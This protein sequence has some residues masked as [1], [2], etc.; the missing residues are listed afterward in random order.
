VPRVYIFDDLNNVT[1]DPHVV[2]RTEELVVVYHVEGRAEVEVANIEI[3]IEVARVVESI[4]QVLELALGVT[5]EYAPLLAYME[6][7]VPKA[8][9]QCHIGDSASPK[10]IK[11]TS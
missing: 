5:L 11:G 2:H 10:F 1:W 4:H 3:V 7:I 6:G 8:V 9:V